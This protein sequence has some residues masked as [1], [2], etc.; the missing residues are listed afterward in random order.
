MVRKFISIVKH[1]QNQETVP[2]NIR[3]TG[4]KGVLY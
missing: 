2:I 3:T 1:T 4:T